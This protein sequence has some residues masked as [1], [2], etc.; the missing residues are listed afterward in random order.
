MRSVCCALALCLASA[1]AAQPSA[2]L[3]DPLARYADAVLLFE[4]DAYALAA[5]RFGRYLAAEPL[6]GTADDG[7]ARLRAGLYRALAAQRADLPD[8]G[9]LLERFVDRYSPRPIAIEAVRQVADVA[10]AEKDYERAADQYRRLPLA[11][12]GRERADEVR[13]RLGYT[14]FATKDFATASRYLGDLRSRDGVYREPATY[15]YALARYY[16]N[17]LGGARRAF[18]ALGSSERYARV[19]PGYLAQLY[20]AEGDYE[21][22][23]AYAA[24]V[25][26]AGE[27]RQLPQLALLVGR[28][29]FE[30]GRYPEALPYLEYGAE[31][32]GELSAADFYQLGYVQYQAGEYEAAATNLRHLAAENTALGQQGLYYLGNAYLRLGRRAEARPAF[33]AVSR[34]AYG[35]ALREEA[36]WNV[37]KLN[38]ELGYS[39]EALE[40]LGGIPATSPR[41]AE[42]QA[43]LARVVLASRDYARAL[44]ILDGMGPGLSPS[45]R[46]ARQRVLVLRGLQLLQREEL[47]EAAELLTRSLAA[48]PDPYYE[49]LALYWLGDVSFRQND[50]DAARERLVAFLQR[51]PELS[52]PLPDDA[53]PGTASYTL[54]Y[55]DFRR[56]RYGTALG[57]FQEAVA[58]LRRRTRISGEAPALRRL[59][60][61]AVL[62][63]GD[64]N[65][66]RNDYA[67]ASRFYDEAIEREYAGYVYA[68]YQR[69]II[70]GLQGETTAKIVDLEAI[71][72][73]H[74]RGPFADDA[75]LELGVTYQSIDRLR[76]AQAA[77]ERLLRD[78]P[79]SENRNEATLQLGL[80]AYN[81]GNPAAAV[82]Y[83]KQV[84]SND[85]TAAEARTAQ[86]ALQ[87][88]YVQD[89]G[90]PDDYL[91]FLGTIP[92]FKLSDAVR[93][94]VN[95]SAATAQYEAGEYARAI[96]QYGAYLG[97]Y[98]EGGS[99][100]EAYYRRADSY[101]LLERPAEAL[102]DLE[103]LADAGPGRYYGEALG[104]AAD[105]A[106]AL[107]DHAKAYG[108]YARL[109]E[110]R[111]EAAATETKLSA[112]RAAAASGETAAVQRLSDGLT[113]DPTLTDAD[114]AVVSFYRGK[115]AYAARDYDRALA[116]F[117]S[118]IRNDQGAA[119]AEARYLVARIYYLRRDLDLAESIAVKAQR[120]S[121]AYPYWVARSTLLLIDVFLDREDDLSARAVAEGLVA[122]YEGDPELEAE[123]RRKL[124]EVNRLSADR[125][126]V[127]PLDTGVIELADP[128]DEGPADEGPSDGPAPTPPQPRND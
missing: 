21:G 68:L 5:G 77:Y 110:L 40:A 90:R 13:F 4:H 37:A 119:A 7:E 44:T 116:A 65:F 49:A 35:E 10:F 60:G 9:F 14:S 48:P 50:L 66:K 46:E 72:E 75:L 45:L 99:A 29:Y 78:Y 51:V 57:H 124:A 32:A 73:R 123:A 76:E 111:G 52:A 87:E 25:V 22:V 41:Y 89:L 118:V 100:R 58:E 18:E 104:R 128:T 1:G 92:G 114:R 98:P 117:N 125:S 39:Q 84:F 54:G 53:N 97:A 24:P 67:A 12:L 80:V 34:M 2:A 112:L 120:E 59:L 16:D 86:Q 70:A 79:R 107:G 69:A 71:V 20:F 106:S 105:V 33:A 94:S 3:D 74:P 38:Y 47:S 63:A 96:E 101:L 36:A 26:R 82:D 8:A 88:I 27:A 85:P 102:A 30:L 43:L 81:Q 95:F 56:R 91:A 23:V 42:A 108:Y 83:Y 17:D 122:N 28:A 103:A 115:A 61:D 15:Y 121:S 19:L 93:D 109:L 113:A 64:A 127:S 126:R 62:R 11:G 6:P 55:V 31:H